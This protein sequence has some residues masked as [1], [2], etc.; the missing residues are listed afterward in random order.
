[1][2]SADGPSSSH[3]AEVERQIADL[4]QQAEAAY[5]AMYDCRPSALNDLCDDAVELLGR[6]A[7]LAG[8]LGDID[9]AIALTGRTLHIRAVHRQLR[10]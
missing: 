2:S 4:V 7:R 3:P 8:S 9:R 5:A 10:T 1:M 6:A